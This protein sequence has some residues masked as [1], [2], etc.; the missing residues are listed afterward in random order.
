MTDTQPTQEPEPQDTR[1][2]IIQAAA[3]VFAEEGYARATT[4]QIAAESG[5]TEMTLFRHFGSK[6]NLFAAVLDHYVIDQDAAA[7]LGGNLSGDYTQD[8]LVMGRYMMHIMLERRDAMRMM[9]CEA[10]HF[11]ELRETL[12]QA[13]RKLR[14]RVAAYLRKQIKAYVVKPRDPDMMAQAFMGFFFSYTL[15][16]TF[17]DRALAIESPDDQLVV[18][19]VDLFVQGTLQP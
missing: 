18:E 7:A 10:D 8:M 15:A 2:K 16:A 9:L 14:E 6:Q 5:F 12:G 4:R 17:L 11:P 1:G 13:P 3:D 19:F